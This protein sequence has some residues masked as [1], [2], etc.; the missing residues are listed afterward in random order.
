MGAEKPGTCGLQQTAH[1]LASRH[2]DERVGFEQ[3]L[4]Q[5]L[6]ELNERTRR[7]YVV[8]A[9]KGE[10]AVVTLDLIWCRTYH[11]RPEF[12]APRADD[13]PVEVHGIGNERARPHA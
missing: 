5:R 7:R 6:D 3:I 13:M 12:R 2:H 10:R 1:C 9:R 8:L 4:P 11:R